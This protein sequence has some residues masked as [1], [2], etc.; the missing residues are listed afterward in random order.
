MKKPSCQLTLQLDKMWSF[1]K[2]QREKQWLG[3]ERRVGSSSVP[4]LY[5][6]DLEVLDRSPFVRIKRHKIDFQKHWTIDN[7]I[8]YLYSTAYCR[9]NYFNGD[10][11]VFQAEIKAAILSAEPSGL[12]V[13]DVPISVYLGF[14]D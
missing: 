4:L 7:F 13:E 3:E 11:S 9:R 5:K 12:F 14:K 2:N 10:T 8:G 6:S 1:V